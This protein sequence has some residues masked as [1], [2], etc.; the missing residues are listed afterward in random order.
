M[1]N[2]NTRQDYEWETDFEPSF[3]LNFGEEEYVSL[4]D[5]E[6]NETAR[7]PKRFATLSNE[8]MDKIL[9]EKHSVKTK[10]TTNWS[11]ATF[12]GRWSPMNIFKKL[13]RNY[14]QTVKKTTKNDGEE[15][16]SSFPGI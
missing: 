5:N 3:R 2:D 15:L 10:R 4:V 11:V 13:Y 6:K 7:Q 8:E 16:G 14:T 12:K 9:E 1:E